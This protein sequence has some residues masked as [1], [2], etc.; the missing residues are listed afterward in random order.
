[1]SLFLWGRFVVC[2]PRLWGSVVLL[3]DILGGLWGCFPYFR[4]RWYA[5][6]VKCYFEISWCIYNQAYF[7]SSIFTECFVEQLATLFL[8]RFVGSRLVILYKPSI[9]ES[10]CRLNDTVY[11]WT[12]YYFGFQQFMLKEGEFYSVNSCSDLQSEFQ[13]Q[14]FCG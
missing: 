6:V 8:S 9:K 11:N 14:I 10:S 1:M 5:D 12:L 13:L 2:L 7:V 4:G 3:G